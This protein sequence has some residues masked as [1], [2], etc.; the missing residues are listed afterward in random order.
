[1]SVHVITYEISPRRV[2]SIFEMSIDLGE[3]TAAKPDSLGRH[4]F[5]LVCF[6]IWNLQG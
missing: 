2:C 6:N 4:K 3:R 1:M 5:L